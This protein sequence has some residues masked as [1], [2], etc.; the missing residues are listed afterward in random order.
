MVVQVR[1]TTVVQPG[2]PVTSANVVEAPEQRSEATAEPPV[3]AGLEI[4]ALQSVV[5]VGGKKVKV[6]AVVSE[7]VKV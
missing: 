7:M 3:L 6:G 1:V 2:D 4:S 5:N